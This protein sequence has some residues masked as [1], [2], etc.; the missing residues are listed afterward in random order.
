VLGGHYAK[1]LLLDKFRSLTFA[2]K[3]VKKDEINNLVERDAS[4]IGYY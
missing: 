3:Q 1:N 2:E 4:E